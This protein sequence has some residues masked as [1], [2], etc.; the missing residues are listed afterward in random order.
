MTFNFSQIMFL[1]LQ[2]EDGFSKL[3]VSLKQLEA[4]SLLTEQAVPKMF[5]KHITC[6]VFYYKT[7][8]RFALI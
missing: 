4:I 2:G 7:N 8:Q 6:K 3:H 5:G 1:L